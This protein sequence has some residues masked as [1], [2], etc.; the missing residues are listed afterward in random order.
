MVPKIVAYARFQVQWHAD[1]WAYERR[2]RQR[3]EKAFAMEIAR[4]A[5][6]ETQLRILQRH[7]S[8]A[9]PH[10]YSREHERAA[11]CE[12]RK[13]IDADVYTRIAESELYM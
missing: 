11:D 3:A 2:H 6:L 4:R 5:R 1:E 7:V 8:E 9:D 10:P 13:N 12:M